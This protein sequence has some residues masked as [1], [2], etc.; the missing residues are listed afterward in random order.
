MKYC[1]ECGSKVSLQQRSLE[2]VD[3][4]VCTVCK[5]IFHQSP[6]LSAGCIAEWRDSVLLCQRALRPEEGQWELPAGFVASGES[7][8][9]AAIR[10]TLEE[11]N[12]EV[13]IQGVY[14]LLH[15]THI[16][17]LRVIYLAR[18]LD[19]RFKPGPETLA[20]RLF[21][22]SEIPWGDLA[23]ATT[24]EALRRYFTDRKSGK[25]ELFFA[26]VVPFDVFARRTVDPA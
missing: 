2:G 13:E 10:E 22:E 26:D 3:R 25:F 21:R 8:R 9:A 24:R 6:R 4:F 15:L 1:S 19:C 12:A 17:Q 11:A 14:G 16:D 5:R 23:F 7:T 18:L 20:V